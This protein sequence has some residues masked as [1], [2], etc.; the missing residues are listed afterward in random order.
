MFAV[1]TSSQTLD[2]AWCSADVVVVVVVV[3][4]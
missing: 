1:V 3:V 4:V 2:V